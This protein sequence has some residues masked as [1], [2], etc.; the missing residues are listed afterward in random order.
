MYCGTSVLIFDANKHHLIKMSLSSPKVPT[1]VKKITVKAIQKGN[2]KRHVES[3]HSERQYPCA[4]CDYTATWKHNLKR[5]VEAAHLDI[6]YPCDKCDYKSKWKS[7][8]KKHEDAVHLDI[9]FPCDK[10]DYKANRKAI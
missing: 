7:A 5:H 1:Q 9:Q 3:K 10:C 4:K 2:K 8:L 6:Q